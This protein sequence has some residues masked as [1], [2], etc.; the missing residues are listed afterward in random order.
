MV[1]FMEV[2]LAFLMNGAIRGHR[3]SGSAHLTVFIVAWT[4]EEVKF[5]KREDLLIRKVSALDEA[6]YA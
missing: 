2:V 4:D 3:P 6:V 1:D 5:R